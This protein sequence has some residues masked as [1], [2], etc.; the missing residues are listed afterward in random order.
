MDMLTSYDEYNLN[1]EKKGKFTPEEILTF[2]AFNFFSDEK[3]FIDLPRTRDESDG[4]GKEK[5]SE[6]M[7]NLK[8]IIRQTMTATIAGPQLLVFPVLKFFF[9]DFVGW[10]GGGKYR[11]KETK[12]A[13]EFIE[14]LHIKLEKAL[15]TTGGYR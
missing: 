13:L 5:T 8:K 2:V 1:P 14:V 6:Q 4:E 12:D 15:R 11:V 3:F 7:E 9:N 10:T